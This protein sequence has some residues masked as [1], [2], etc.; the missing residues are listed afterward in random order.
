MPFLTLDSPNILDFSNMLYFLN[1]T[2]FLFYNLY[3]P[4]E[5]WP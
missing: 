4:D 1:V 5:H 3:F 2:P